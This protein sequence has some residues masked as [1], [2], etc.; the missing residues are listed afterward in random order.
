MQANE[1]K[2]ITATVALSDFIANRQ[3]QV[4]IYN[5]P[6]PL[7]KHLELVCI[8][9][10]GLCVVKNTTQITQDVVSN[11]NIHKIEL[12]YNLVIELD[13]ALKD[14]ILDLIKR[15]GSIKHTEQKTLFN[16]KL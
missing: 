16:E 5:P 2:Y 11:K 10:S 4:G 9:E 7:D 8:L 15:T 3:L 1:L 12:I 14:D 6:I 13:V